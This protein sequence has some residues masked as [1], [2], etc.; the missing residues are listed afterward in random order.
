M[1]SLSL[2][3]IEIIVL[4]LGAIVLGITIHFF[5]TS[6]KSM[7]HTPMEAEKIS[8][9]LEEWKLR[10]FNDTELKDKELTQV[11]KRL[12]EAEE[13]NSIN[14]IEADEMRKLNKKVEIGN[15]SI[16]KIHPGY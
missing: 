10:Y 11:R 1:A 14:S 16:T 4:M 9:N 15:R 8:K 7:K 2:S 13:N 3:I 12:E 5:I 6:R